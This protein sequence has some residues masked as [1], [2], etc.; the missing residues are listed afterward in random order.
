MPGFNI[1]G[2]STVDGGAPIPPEVRRRHRWIFKSFGDGV[3]NDQ[4]LL[5]LHSANRPEFTLEQPE[6][7]HDQEV[8]YFAGKQTWNEIEMSFYDS[9]QDPDSS[10]EIWRWV[11]IVSDINGGVRVAAPDNYKKQGQLEMIDGQGTT[12]ETW[13]LYNCWPRVTNWGELNYDNTELAEISVTMRYDRAER[14][15]T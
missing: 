12:T 13:K 5:L 14:V 7:H 11:K 6:L 8:I 3:P 15:T 4:V 9:E 2:A 10:A 1:P